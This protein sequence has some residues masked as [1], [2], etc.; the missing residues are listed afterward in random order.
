MSDCAFCT[1]A[2]S[3]WLQDCW[4]KHQE[5][6]AACWHRRGRAAV[7]DDQGSDGLHE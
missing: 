1:C 6:E 4:H 2:S 3:W 7:L 5:T